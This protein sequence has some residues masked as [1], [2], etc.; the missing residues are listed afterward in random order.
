MFHWLSTTVHQPDVLSPTVTTGISCCFVSKG[1]HVYM[2]SFCNPFPS[3][4]QAPLTCPEIVVA[5]MRVHFFLGASASIYRPAVWSVLISF[6]ICCLPLQLP[7]TV[8][9]R[10]SFICFKLISLFQEL[11]P[12][13]S[14]AGTTGE[15]QFCSTIL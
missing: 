10:N 8:S 11:S 1:K 4:C 15:K 14:S 3:Y 13:S 7:A 9:S 5:D 6:F 2:T 12:N